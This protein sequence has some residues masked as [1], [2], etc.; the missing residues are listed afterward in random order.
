MADTPGSNGAGRPNDG[1]PGEQPPA[2]PQTGGPPG[3]SPP[4]ASPIAAA[5][6]GAP[7]VAMPGG[8]EGDDVNLRLARVDRNDMGNGERLLAR[9]GQDLLFVRELGWHAWDGRYWDRD[10]AAAELRRRC[11]ATARSVMEEV[12]AVQGSNAEDWGGTGDWKE[13]QQE[14]RKWSIGSGNRARIEAMATE[15]APYVTVGPADMD[16]D[17]LLFNVD[18]G[19]I[20][21]VGACD[22]FRPHARTD[23]ISRISPAAYD[24]DATC[25]LWFKF[26]CEVQPDTAIRLFLQRWVGYC[27]TGLTI[28]QKLIFN[29]GEGANGKSVFVET[30]AWLL[31][32]YALTL[33]FASLL[34]DDRKRGGDA[35][36]DIARLPGVRMVRASEPEK[37]ST[38]S[39]ATIK[40]I[41]GNEELT[42]RHLH[43]DFF[44]F[45]AQFKLTL[46]GNHKP[47][48]RGQ[49]HGIWRRFLLVPW[50]VMVPEEDQ[51]LN[52][53]DKLKAEASGI[54]NWALDGC[55]MWL[56][57]GLDVPAGVRVA[58]DEYRSDSDP[59]GRFLAACTEGMPGDSVEGAEIYAAYHKWCKANAERTWSMTAFGRALAE[60]GY[61][62]QRGNRVKYL[63]VRLVNVPETYDEASPPPHGDDD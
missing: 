24:P 2:D 61:E 23:R 48:I 35:T 60:R 4:A 43:H 9:H 8:G 50:K 10:G 34:K 20:R 16:A 33:P 44:D 3:A 21:L 12:Q 28:E 26:L 57:S 19:T 53:A 37:G 15:A 40:Q 52:L 14:L 17:P 5:V 31:G 56:E 32:T 13:R 63:N 62:K 6:A 25:D 54:L 27:L 22:D 1:E 36:P 45:I 55:R 29:F 39:E 59:V 58:T 11:H 30:I 47:M 7:L 46:S 18:N 41:T 49:D 51:D 42:A 38:F